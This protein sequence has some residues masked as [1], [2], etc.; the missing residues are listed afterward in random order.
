MTRDILNPGRKE[1]Q[2]EAKFFSSLTNWCQNLGPEY[3]KIIAFYLAHKHDKESDLSYPPPPA[4]SNKCISCDTS[5]EKLYHI[6]DSVYQKKFFEPESDMIRTCLGI[7]KNLSMIGRGEGSTW[8]D[9]GMEDK[10]ANL[11]HFS[12]D[13]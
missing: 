3:D 5:L 1:Q 7:L 10:V 11:F 13:P 12:K 4:Y 6:Q 8:A 2:A 9:P